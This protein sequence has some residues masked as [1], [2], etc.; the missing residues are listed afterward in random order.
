E[1]TTKDRHHRL[2]CSSRVQN[3]MM[4]KRKDWQMEMDLKLEESD[5][6]RVAMTTSFR[7]RKIMAIDILTMHDDES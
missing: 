6:H 3:R 5:G 1:A 4:G 7:Q 2:Q